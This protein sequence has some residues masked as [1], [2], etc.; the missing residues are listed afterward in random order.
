MK[1]FERVADAVIR[2]AMKRPYIHLPGYMSRYWII[3]YNR[4]GLAVR[5]HHIERSDKDRHFHD[6]PW[7][8]VS[9]VLRGGYFERTPCRPEA[10]CYQCAFARR[11]GL[12]DMEDDCVGEA[13]RRW[14]GPGSIAF[15]QATSWHRLQLSPLRGADQCWTLFITGPARQPWGFLVGGEKVPAK[16]YLG[17]RFIDTKYEGAAA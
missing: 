6:H 12:T 17:D 11:H 14:R 10:L 5:V 7:W 4:T 13:P 9:I 2:F 8:Y 16:D 1:L 15:R 3:P